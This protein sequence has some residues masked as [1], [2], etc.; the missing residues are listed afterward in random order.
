MLE[1]QVFLS[2]P[3]FGDWLVGE[4][5]KPTKDWSARYPLSSVSDRMVG[6]PGRGVQVKGSIIARD[7]SFHG[8]AVP[9]FVAD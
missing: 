8:T 7:W 2:P 3:E 9:Y 1:K 5:V 4:E 6:E